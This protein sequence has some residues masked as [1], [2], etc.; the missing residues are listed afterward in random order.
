MSTPNVFVLQ[1][2]N[3]EGDTLPEVYRERAK[4]ESVAVAHIEAFAAISSDI[5]YYRHS[6][7]TGV[8]Y[9]VAE[10]NAENDGGSD[11]AVLTLEE[12]ELYEVERYTIRKAV[13][14]E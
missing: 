3:K 14:I 2:T 11:D 12:A 5:V 1:Y 6:E 7:G 9:I 4:A 8:T 10:W 13:V